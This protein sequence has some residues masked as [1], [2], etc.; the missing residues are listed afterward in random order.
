MPCDSIT[1]QRLDLKVANP[2]LLKEAFQKAGYTVQEY[3]KRLYVQKGGLSGTFENGVLTSATIGEAEVNAVRKQYSTI[4]VTR[5][6]QRFGGR[7]QM[8]G[9][10]KGKI[11]MRQ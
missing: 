7:V 8:T 6:A 2:G 1:Y 10:N 5:A 3:G 11:I 4:C 9:P